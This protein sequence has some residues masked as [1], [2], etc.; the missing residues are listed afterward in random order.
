MKKLPIYNSTLLVLALIFSTMAFIAKESPVEGAK[1]ADRKA[2]FLGQWETSKIYTLE[3]IEAM[4]EGSFDFKPMGV[5]SVRTFAQQLK[6]L[7]VVIFGMNSVFIKDEA[8]MAPDPDIENTGLS[9]AEVKAFVESSFD[10]VTATVKGMSDEELSEEREMMF[11]PGKP[12]FTKY[13]YLDFIRDHCAHHRGQALVYLRSA[14]I[15]P[16]IYKYFPM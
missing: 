2:L 9:K 7:G 16:P 12:K 1:A 3:I 14:G 4:P 15:T 11:M 10:M 6:H 5:D 13:E 8:P